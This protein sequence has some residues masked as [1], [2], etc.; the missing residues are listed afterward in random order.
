M[1]IERGLE[2]EQAACEYLVGHGMRCIARNVRY[3][4]GELDLVMHD[5][6]TLVFVEVRARTSGRYGGAL[7]SIDERK[8]HRLRLAAQRFLLRYR[9]QVPRCRFDIVTFE[10]GKVAWIRDAFD[11]GGD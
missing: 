9:A 7:A 6:D 8:Q 2:Y 4:F 5:V 11:A 3:R 10:A 1:S